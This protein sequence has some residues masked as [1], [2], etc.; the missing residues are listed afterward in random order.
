MFLI[1]LNSIL[2]AQDLKGITELAK[3]GDLEQL[4][5]QADA[6]ILEHKDT[7]PG[8]DK[9]NSKETGKPISEYY[10]IMMYRTLVDVGSDNQKAISDQLAMIAEIKKGYEGTSVGNAILLGITTILA[11][12]WEKNEVYDNSEKLYRIAYENEAKW[13]D[14]KLNMMFM[15]AQALYNNK[16]YDEA[17]K[18][19]KKYIDN[20]E[21][22]IK[23]GQ[24]ACVIGSF[25]GIA[26]CYAEKN[27]NKNTKRYVEM[28][29]KC[30]QE[31]KDDKNIGR[32]TEMKKAIE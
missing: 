10:F 13:S 30:A 22:Y 6:Y 16:K 21:K 23:D 8:K 12:N 4:R 1:L 29:L 26:L 18:L 11:A 28:G 9:A 31:N 5:V 14:K 17:I 19:Y 20:K 7:L 15:Y 24:Y 3:A 25:S 32:F 27:D 2:C